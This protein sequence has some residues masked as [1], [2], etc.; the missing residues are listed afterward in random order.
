M[1]LSPVAAAPV[2]LGGSIAD[3]TPDPSPADAFADVLEANRAYVAGHAHSGLAAAARR[4]LA[5][6]TCIDSRIEPLQMLGLV[7]GD[8][9]ILRNAGARVTEDAIRSLTLATSLLG[10]R[11]VM[12]VAHTDCAMRGVTDEQLRAAIRD[13]QPGVQIGA[14]VLHAAPDPLVNLRD[15]LAV[16]R[17]PG[18]LPA[19]VI[20]SGFEYDVHS[21]EL[22]VMV[23]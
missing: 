8:A 22:R 10:V 2:R 17:T 16:L 14:M 6:L 18:V 13:A 23:P 12:V 21:G 3:V 20:A 19:G 5:V 1:M 7:P 4:G 15:D 9:K 11:R